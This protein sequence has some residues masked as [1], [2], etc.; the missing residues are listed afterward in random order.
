MSVGRYLALKCAVGFGV[1]LVTC[2]LALLLTGLFASLLPK[3]GSM[4]A[5]AIVGLTYI[6]T[7][8]FLT[9]AITEK[10]SKRWSR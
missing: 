10:L 1:F 9:H 5:F 6:V 7:S 8:L 4:V 2:P 3:A